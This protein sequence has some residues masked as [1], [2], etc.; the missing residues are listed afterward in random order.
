[1]ECMGALEKFLHREHE[2]LSTLVKAALVHVQFETIHPFLDGNGRLG[3]LLITF[4]L[5]V[6]GAIREPILYL[7]LYL[8]R[9]RQNYYELIDRVRT[10]GEWKSGSNSFWRA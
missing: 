8:K 1:M 2:D 7:S 6:A 5:C 4:L 9:N 3:R 10:H